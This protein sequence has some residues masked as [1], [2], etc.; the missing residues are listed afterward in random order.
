MDNSPSTIDN[1]LGSG[2]SGLGSSWVRLAVYDLLGREVAVLADGQKTPGVYSVSFNADGLSSGVYF[3]RLTGEGFY[4][5][6]K[7]VVLR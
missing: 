1:R 4:D 6:K 2:V 5:V 3:C 7:M